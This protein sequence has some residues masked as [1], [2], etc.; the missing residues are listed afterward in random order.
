MMRLA[1]GGGGGGQG[2]ECGRQQ[3]GDAGERVRV[4]YHTFTC[5]CVAYEGARTQGV[6][7]HKRKPGRVE[8][9]LP[10]Q[11]PRTTGGANP[12]APQNMHPSTH[13]PHPCSLLTLVTH[14]PHPAQPYPAS[15]HQACSPGAGCRASTGCSRCTG[16]PRCSTP[17]SHGR[18]HTACPPHTDYR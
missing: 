18:A 14:L 7:R 3:V 10:G 8:E 15:S 17:G 11:G 4:S 13:V 9:A 5:A 12:S 16:T 2:L 6:G 1:V